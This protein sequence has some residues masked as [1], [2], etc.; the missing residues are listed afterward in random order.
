MNTGGL[1]PQ[2][3]NL[4]IQKLVIGIAVLLFLVKIFAYVLTHSVAIL[5]DALEGTVNVVAGFIGLYSLY[6]AAKPRDI[7]HPYGHGKAEFISAAV[8]GTLIT[9]AGVVIIY[10]SIQGLLNPR[11]LHQL[12]YGILL[13]AFTALVNF[14]V[15]YI[16]IKKGKKNNSLALIA[17]GKHLQSDTYTTLGIILGLILIYFTGIIWLDSIVA[18]LFAL[19]IMYTGYKIVRSSIAGIMDEAD[20]EILEKMVAEMNKER[21]PNWV[22]FH[23]LRVIKYGGQLHVDA[24]VTVPWYFNIHEAHNEIDHFGKIIRTHFGDSLEMFIH[25]DG[26]LYHQCSL[27][28]K[29]NCPVR[30]LEF[31]HRVEWTLENVLSNEKHSLEKWRRGEVEK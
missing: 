26:C 29:E 20:T 27:C 25:T 10:E 31:R 17:S 4:R 13:V 14:S 11:T 2:K 1:S 21:Q 16:S 18:I 12:D 7:D 3:E 22:D 9:V 23:N 15:G 6:V 5:T 28:Y 24:H 19:F 30:K 8:E